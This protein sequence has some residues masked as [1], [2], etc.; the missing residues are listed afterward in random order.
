MKI[1]DIDADIESPRKKKG[2]FDWT[3]NL[4]HVFIVISL[5][6]SASGLYAHDEARMAIIETKVDA[7]TEQNLPPRVSALEAQSHDLHESLSGIRDVLVQIRNSLDTK[8]D[9]K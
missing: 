2:M 6:I 4:G 3:V 5:L 8:A 1:E 9:K 7:I